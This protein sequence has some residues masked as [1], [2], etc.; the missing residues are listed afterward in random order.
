MKAASDSH[1]S[2]KD[3]GD[4]L[5]FGSEYIT[6]TKDSYV[7]RKS[8]EPNSEPII[9]KIKQNA[10]GIDTE[11]RISLLKGYIEDNFA[12]MLNMTTDNRS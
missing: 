1:L 8:D 12:D 9:I 2:K 5:I 3:Y 4:R 11:D 7:R 10:K 6:C